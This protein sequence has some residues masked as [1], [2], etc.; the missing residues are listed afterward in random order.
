MLFVTDVEQIECTDA[1][2][3]ILLSGKCR[4]LM[5]ERT[6]APSARGYDDR[7][8]LRPEI[9]YQ[10]RSFLFSVGKVLFGCNLPEYKRCFHTVFKIC[11]RKYNTN[12]VNTKNTNTKSVNNE[13][14]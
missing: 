10:M 8:D 1:K 12:Y 4:S 3:F 7:I 6:F 5:H 2:I 11:H 13:G 14:A 9:G